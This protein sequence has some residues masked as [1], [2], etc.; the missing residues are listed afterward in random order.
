VGWKKWK[1]WIEEIEDG[2]GELKEEERKGRNYFGGE[3]IYVGGFL[4]RKEPFLL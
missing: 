4:F 1:R 3:V 2:E